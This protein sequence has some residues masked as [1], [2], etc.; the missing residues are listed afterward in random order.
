MTQELKN[1]FESGSANGAVIDVA[2]IAGRVLWG[3]VDLDDH[4]IVSPTARS[5]L[6]IYTRSKFPNVE[7]FTEHQNSWDSAFDSQLEPKLHRGGSPDQPLPTAVVFP[8]KCHV[9]NAVPERNAKPYRREVFYSN[10][11]ASHSISY[12]MFFHSG[13]DLFLAGVY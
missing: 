8:R 12:G 7:E 9:S 2:G 4:N 11:W 10:R 6:F 3:P 5:K 1:L 13:E